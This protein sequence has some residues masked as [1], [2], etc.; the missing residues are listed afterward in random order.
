MVTKMSLAISVQVMDVP[1]KFACISQGELQ[2]DEAATPLERFAERSW[3]L[4]HQS[5]DHEAPRKCASQRPHISRQ[6]FFLVG[7]QS[8]FEDEVEKL[9]CVFQCRQTAIVEIGRRILDSAKGKRL[10][11]SFGP[12]G[13][14]LLHTQVVHLVV[15]KI[16]RRMAGAAFGLSKKD[17]LAM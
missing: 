17:R 5:G 12:A 14:K 3:L 15:R 11:P 8:Q 10:G 13:I 16:R 6:I 2:V 4:P 7:G 1:P 9:N